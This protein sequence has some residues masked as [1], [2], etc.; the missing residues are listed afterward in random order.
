MKKEARIWK[1]IS[2][3]KVQCNLCNH[4]CKI[5]NNNTGICGV[6]KVENNKLNTLIYGSCS[7]IHTDPIEKKPLYHFYPGTNALSLGT[8]G[9]NFKCLHCQNYS[10]S[11]ADINYPYLK[12]ITPEDSVK[13][14]KQYKCQGIAYT[15]NEPTIWYEF[16][17]DSAKVAK[18]NNLY[19]V[20][21]TNGY[22]SKDPLE[23]ISSN[24]DAMNID[25]KAFKE[26]FYKKVCKA[27]LQPVLETCIYAKEL[28]IHIELTYLV[29]AGINDSLREIKNFI[30]WIIEKLGDDTPVHFSCFHPDYKMTD[31]S[32][33]PMD[34]MLKI[35]NL[36]KQ[37][38]LLFPYLGNIIHGDYED[39]HC[40]KCGNICILRNGFIIE[41]DGIKDGNCSKCGFK[42]LKQ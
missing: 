40:P 22:I 38:G 23:E 17:Y 26:D 14:A 28:G 1:T 6:R 31:I 33:T 24:L 4:N 35:Y 8:I 5:S 13:Y 12:E 30:R 27:K 37:E 20:Y 41:K 7:S 2:E 32:R 18:E 11:T 9:C 39:T 21:V 10:I 29:I 36:A 15:Y 16:T 19:T 25:V 42:I 34:T 3:G